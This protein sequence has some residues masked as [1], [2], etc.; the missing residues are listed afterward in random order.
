[1]L[2]DVK[3]IRKIDMFTPLSHVSM[4]LMAIRNSQNVDWVKTWNV[5]GSVQEQ[6]EMRIT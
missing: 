5:S 6:C 3:D 2:L 4:F 1:M